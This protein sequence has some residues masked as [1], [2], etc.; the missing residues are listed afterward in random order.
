[1]QERTHTITEQSKKVHLWSIIRT[2]VNVKLC[3]VSSL[4]RDTHTV[5]R[6]AQKEG[7]LLSYHYTTS[8]FSVSNSL[9]STRK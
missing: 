2:V 9:S 8:L 6:Q 7:A 4:K 1:M 3:R 5:E